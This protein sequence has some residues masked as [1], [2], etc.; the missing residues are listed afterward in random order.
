MLGVIRTRAVFCLG[1]IHIAICSK[2]VDRG[3]LAASLEY[4]R[5][6]VTISFVR[7]RSHWHDG[8]HGYLLFC[9]RA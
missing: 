5:Q 2:W 1:E 4:G 8:F 7:L 9:T 3:E 6:Q